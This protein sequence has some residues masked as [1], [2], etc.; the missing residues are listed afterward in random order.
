M[1]KVLQDI[2]ILS[3]SGVT[4]FSRVFDEKINAQLFGGFMSALD[5]FAH[6]FSDTGIESFE[7]S[8]KRFS[9]LK[10]NNI[11]FIANSEKK[12]KEK[13]V[14]KELDIIIE[15]FIQLY[16]DKLKNWHGDIDIFH[17]FKKEIKESLEDRI[18]KFEKKFW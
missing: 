9:F 16:G 2:W 1:G 5:S 12:Y 11:L 14:H 8:N 10:R 4:L 15:R 18:K 13:K 6:T 3:D 17:G 7:L